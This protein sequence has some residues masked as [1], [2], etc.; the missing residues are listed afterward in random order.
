MDDQPVWMK[1]R[2][3]RILSMPY[4]IGVNDTRGVIWYH[5]SSEEF[6]DLIVDQF[7]EMLEQSERQPLVLDSP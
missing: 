7:D 2:S 3:G 4:P 1:T 5:C 6:A